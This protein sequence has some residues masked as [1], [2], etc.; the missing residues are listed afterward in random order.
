MNGLAS[1]YFQRLFPIMIIAL[2]VLG[3]GAYWNERGKQL[4]FYDEMG[5]RITH[6]TNDTLEIWINEQI[7]VVQTLAED[8]RV[9]AACFNPRDSAAVDNAKKFLKQVHSKYPHYENIPLMAKL[10]KD[11][12][13]EMLVNGEKKLV[14]SGQFFSDT[15]DGK[16]IGKGGED[17]RFIKEVL[18]GAPYFIS[19]VYPSFLRGNPLFVVSAPVKK[20]GVVVGAILVAPQMSYFTD[21]FIDNNRTGNTGYMMML[22][23]RGMV[24]S[25]PRKEDILNAKTSEKFKP[26]LA[27]IN[28]GKTNFAIESDGVEKRYIVAKLN[29]DGKY[30]TNQWYIVFAQEIREILSPA[31]R[32]TWIVDGIVFLVFLL[33]TLMIYWLTRTI[34]L[35]PIHDTSVFLERIS[36]GDYSTTIGKQFLNRKDE[37][38]TWARALNDIS[39]NMRKMISKISQS[40]E[41]VAASSEEFAASAD[42]SSQ[43]AN[44]VSGSISQV[45]QGAEVQLNAVNETVIVLDK[46]SVAIQQVAT[47]ANLAAE[48]SYRAAQTAKEG[49]QSIEAAVTQ[50]L[51]IKQTVTTLS[52]EI[53]K[54][55]GQSKEIGQIV[56]TI[57]GIAGQTNLLA[58]NAAIE[59][60]RAGEQGRGFA[61]VAEEVRKLAEQSQ[62][63]AKQIAQMIGAIQGDTEQTIAAMNEGTHE[64]N[65]G[66][67]VVSSAGK[68]FEDII[69]LIMQVSVQVEDISS[70]MQH[71]AAGSQQAVSSVMAI[72]TLSKAAVGE[73]Q[74]V[75]AAAEEQSASM[76]QIAS[77]SQSLTK[78]AQE[79]QE[80]VS[81]FKI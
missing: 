36:Q 5:K 48:K 70:T 52:R 50:M 73:A 22:D 10:G 16:T 68:S 41:H 4:E 13:L 21:R 78:M 67:E 71:I 63:A 61:V 17:S 20:D 75:S 74:T 56:E 64:V 37:F 46:M 33:I 26:L 40:A 12:A 7:N 72:D 51:Q 31:V 65:L 6:G 23:E 30:V 58:L 27:M 80:A 44:Q 32:A 11:Q 28:Q 45:A 57:S 1:R 54:L 53:A 43:A 62:E 39:Q 3:V 35:Q 59:A 9:I 2:V 29:S 49:G 18:A 69:S 79:L 66:A 24:I 8:P 55:G 47:N 60:A 77:S 14:K 25:H 15:V 42:Q 34:I 76:E 19:H 81:I 38:G